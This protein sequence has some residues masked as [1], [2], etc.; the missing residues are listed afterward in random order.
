MCHHTIVKSYNPYTSSHNNPYTQLKC[1]YVIL[2]LHTNHQSQSSHLTQGKHTNIKAP[3]YTQS[4]HSHTNRKPSSIKQIVSLLLLP[5]SAHIYPPPQLT[6]D[7][8]QTYVALL[9]TIS[10][11]ASHRS[12]IP[13]IF[14]NVRFGRYVVTRFLADTNF[15]GHRPTVSIKLSDSFTLH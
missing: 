7:L 4:I 11:K 14:S 15:H 13:S 5:R 10:H 6:Q 8:Q 2:H 12:K 9:L 1:S 3:P